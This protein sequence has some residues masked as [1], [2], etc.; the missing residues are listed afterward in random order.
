MYGW[1]PVVFSPLQQSSFQRTALRRFSR[2]VVVNETAQQAHRYHVRFM[3][4]VAVRHA[5]HDTAYATVIQWEGVRGN[6]YDFLDCYYCVNDGGRTDRAKSR[7][8]Q[9]SRKSTSKF[10]P[11][12]KTWMEGC[13]ELFKLDD[14]D[15]WQPPDGATVV[16]PPHI[17]KTIRQ[18]KTS[19]HSRQEHTLFIKYTL[20]SCGFFSWMLFHWFS[21]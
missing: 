9:R 10:R 8:S 4:C 19:A 5:W 1:L 15:Q 14:P 20:N 11:V 17:E 3:Q 13:G 16:A 6:I 12:E 21:G 2:G 7:L 18:K